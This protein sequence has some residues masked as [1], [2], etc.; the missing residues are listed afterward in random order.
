MKTDNEILDNFGKIVVDNIYD[1][2]MLFHK[3]ILADQTPWGIKKEYVAVTN[4]LDANDQA[5]LT[6][7]M[8]DILSTSLFAFLKVFEEHQEYKI[9]YEEEGRQVNLAEI[10]EMLKAEPIIDD[11]W[12]ARFSKEK[13]NP[14]S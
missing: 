4:K 13:P 1:D 5:I 6:N 11:G 7:Y 14:G 10:S 12:I 3:R 8:H 2:Q 9:V